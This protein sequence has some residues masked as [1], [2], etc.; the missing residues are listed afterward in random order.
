MG[1]LFIII[2]GVLFII[3]ESYLLYR[4]PTYYMGV[5]FIIIGVLF[6]IW[7][8]VLYN[9]GCCR[10]A[11]IVIQGVVGMPQLE[12]GVLCYILQHRTPPSNWGISTT[13]PEYS[14]GPHLPIGAYLQHLQ[15]IAQDPTF[16]L[17]HTYNT[18]LYMYILAGIY[19]TRTYL[20]SHWLT[21]TPVLKTIQDSTLQEVVQLYSQ[22]RTQTL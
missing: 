6:I 13:P 1:V 14:T 20:P 10:Y 7:G 4:S 3:W 9:I 8:P 15:N 16:Q 17:G 2:M 11:P 22:P 21:Q 18:S 5:L 19:S 12:G